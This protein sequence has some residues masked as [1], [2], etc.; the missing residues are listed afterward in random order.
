[1]S[2]PEFHFKKWPKRHAHVVE[3]CEALDVRDVLL[4]LDPLGPARPCSALALEPAPV[5]VAHARPPWRRAAPPLVGFLCPRCRRRCE[6]L[7]IPPDA[8]G[9]DC[10]CRR[11]VYHG[12]LVY[13]SQRYGR[14]HPPSGSQREPAE[15][16]GSCEANHSSTRRNDGS[17]VRRRTRRG[18]SLR[19][20]AS[21]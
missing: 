15:T 21:A 3:A 10:R 9:D 2:L 11:C 20:P 16:R 19:S 12:G 4:H 6:T 17:V 18:S 7:F 5:P 14:C 8:R 1:M 13:A